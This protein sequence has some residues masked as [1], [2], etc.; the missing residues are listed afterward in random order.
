MKVHLIIYYIL[1][2]ASLLAGVVNLK[3]VKEF[4]YLVILIGI[5]ILT[6]LGTEIF[7]RY[8]ANYYL[9]YQFYTPLEYGLLGIYFSKYTN[10]TVLK[11]SIYISIIV[12]IS[13][14]TVSLNTLKNSDYPW[15]LTIIETILILTFGF[16]TLFQI[17]AETDV[18]I[19]QKPSFWICTGLIIYFSGTFFINGVFN[20]VLSNN[21]LET[22][23]NYHLVFNSIFNYLLYIFI[24]VGFCVKK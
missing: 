9:L 17:K 11:K 24:I 1:L 6:E 20:S 22:L 5:S 7:K 15:L 12:F 21:K 10:N 18:S 2:F 16:I 19:F 14:C 3:K 4:R 8:N 23:K 13:F